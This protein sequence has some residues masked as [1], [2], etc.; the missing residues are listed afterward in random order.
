MAIHKN[1]IRENPKHIRAQKD[2]KAP[3]EYLVYSVL[4]GDAHVHKGGADKYGVRNWLKD[5]IRA[6]TYEGAMLRHLKAWAEGEDVDP[7]SGWSHLYH[8]R[9]CCA[10]LLDSEKHGT[11]IDDRQRCESIDQETGVTTSMANLTDR[12]R[13]P[14]RSDE[15]VDLLSTTDAAVWADEFMRVTGGTADRGAMIAW[16]ANMWAATYNPLAR[17][18]SRLKCRAGFQPAFEHSDPPQL[19]PGH[20]CVSNEPLSPAE[21]R[22]LD[23]IE[24][25]DRDSR[26]PRCECGHPFCS[27][28]HRT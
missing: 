4:E 28:C 9:A 20:A 11:L 22:E 14:R 15:T 24:S 1:I 16:F 27:H 2:G 13:E 21:E 3:L 10:I 12:V 19:V 5:H 6:S 7:D 18:I 26:P 17:E 23:F 8:V 25:L